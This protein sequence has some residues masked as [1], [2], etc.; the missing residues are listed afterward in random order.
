[1]IAEGRNG[2]Q[3]IDHIAHAAKPAGRNTIRR[4]SGAAFASQKGQG[5][6]LSRWESGGKKWI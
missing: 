5:R 1:M 4:K 6:G 2:I 3:T